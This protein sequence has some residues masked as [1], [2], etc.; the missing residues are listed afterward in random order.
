M[1]AIPSNLP[2]YD[3]H[4]WKH[5][6]NADGDFQDARNEVLMD[7]SRGAVSY[8]LSKREDFADPPFIAAPVYSPG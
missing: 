5:W 7:E 2:D 3:P 8:W 6:T 1:S 4:D